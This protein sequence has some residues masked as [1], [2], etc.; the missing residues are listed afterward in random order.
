[1]RACTAALTR[2]VCPSRPAQCFGHICLTIFQPFMLQMYQNHFGCLLLHSARQIFNCSANALGIVE[3]IFPSPESHRICLPSLIRAWSESV[4]T[5]SRYFCVKFLKSDGAEHESTPGVVECRG[6]SQVSS[7]AIAVSFAVLVMAP[8][9]NLGTAE[10]Q[11]NVAKAP[12]CNTTQ[13]A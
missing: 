1:M 9:D 4:R 3:T 8:A 11:G 6:R 12:L 2:C 7:T 10:E 13:S 5:N